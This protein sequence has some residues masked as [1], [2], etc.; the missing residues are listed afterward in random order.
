MTLSYPP[1]LPMAGYS[2]LGTVGKSAAPESDDAIQVTAMSVSDAAGSTVIL[3][4]ADIHSGTKY[5]WDA[6]CSLIM[7]STGVPSSCIILSGTHTHTAPGQFYGNQLYDRMTTNDVT[8]GL[9]KGLADDVARRISECAVQA[10]R[11]MEEGTLAIGRGEVWGASSQRARKAFENNWDGNM[12]RWYASDGPARS[13]GAERKADSAKKTKKNKTIGMTKKFVEDIYID[14]RVTAFIGKKEETNKKEK[15][16]RENKKKRASDEDD[17]SRGLLGVL[18][19]FGCHPTSLGSG[20]DYYSSDWCGRAKTVVRNEITAES[21]A[22]Y[23]KNVKKRGSST[24]RKGDNTDACDRQDNEKD[25]YDCVPIVPIGFI[26]GCCGDISPLPLCPV[27]TPNGLGEMKNRSIRDERPAFQGRELRAVV[28]RKVGE[29]CGKVV[30]SLAQSD[31]SQKPLSL[32]TAHELWDVTESFDLSQ[33]L[34]SGTYGLPTLGGAPCGP[35]PQ[36]FPR[37]HAGWPSNTLGKDDP[38]WPKTPLPLLRGIVGSLCPK[39]LP[40]HFVLFSGH[41]VVTVPGEPTVALGWTIETAVIDS[42]PTITSCSVI[43]FSGDYAGY[44]VTPEE[45]DEQMYEGSSMLFGRLGGMVLRDKILELGRKSLG[46]I[47]GRRKRRK[48][49]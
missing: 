2:S 16:T 26:Q 25:D 23:V 10:Y 20:A 32:S 47:R 5:L 22:E 14:P 27:S 35:N 8:T 36:I 21:K 24:R 42:L 37:W 12:E 1:S 6:S 33:G 7:S 39:I 46:G 19:V 41:A 4:T 44:W 15:Q 28:G 29:V 48:L 45:Y 17:P 49:N 3:I 9:R 31:Q 43:G 11:R 18:G 40:L 13:A 38:Q 30:L 34:S